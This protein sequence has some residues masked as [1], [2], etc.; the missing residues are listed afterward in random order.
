MNN[1]LKHKLF[2][3]NFGH[4]CGN[5]HGALKNCFLGL[6]SKGGMQEANNKEG[7]ELK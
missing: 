5:C 2:V 1:A 3:L 7:Q 6:D 4:Y